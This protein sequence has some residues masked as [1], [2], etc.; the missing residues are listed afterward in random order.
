MELIKQ[1]RQEPNCFAVSA[2]MVLR[3]VIDKTYY[4]KLIEDAHLEGLFECIGHRGQEVLWPTYDSP[5]KLK[6][7]H[8]QEIIDWYITFGYTLWLLE[9][10]PRSAPQ[11]M[12]HDA[13]MI[14]DGEDANTRF[15]NLLKG[16]SAILVTVTHALAWDGLK[17]FDPNGERFSKSLLDDQVHEAWVIGQL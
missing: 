13:R 8:P 10:F 9:R 17:T 14:W 3:H 16:R 15:W 6:G 5:I 7:I 11:G 12:E 4:S 1:D 2:V